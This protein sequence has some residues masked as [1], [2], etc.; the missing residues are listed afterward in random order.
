MDLTNA[1]ADRWSVDSRAELKSK[2]GG[3]TTVVQTIFWSR[4]IPSCQIWI[5]VRI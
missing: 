5:C 2:L 1:D 3:L 4:V